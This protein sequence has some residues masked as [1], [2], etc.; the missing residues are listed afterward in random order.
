MQT[1][2]KKARCSESATKEDRLFEARQWFEGDAVEKFTL[3]VSRQHL[4]RQG[5]KIPG[6]Y[7]PRW[8]LRAIAGLFMTAQFAD[9]DPA[10]R[11]SRPPCSGLELGEFRGGF[12][13][14]GGGGFQ[15]V[16]DAGQLDV[17][18]LTFTPVVEVA[19]VVWDQVNPNQLNVNYSARVDVQGDVE[20]LTLPELTVKC[21][22]ANATG[23]VETLPPTLAA[24]AGASGTIGSSTI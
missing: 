24:I 23:D 16:L 17:R 9:G 19:S 7:G 22:S 11:A 14:L 18:P 3:G 20:G 12:F 1:T 5:A 4:G 2:N 6:A 10:T 13:P 8:R 15:F 21:A